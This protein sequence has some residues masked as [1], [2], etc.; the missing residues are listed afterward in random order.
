[1]CLLLLSIGYVFSLHVYGESSILQTLAWDLSTVD[2]NIGPM[3]TFT[4]MWVEKPITDTMSLLTKIGK[5]TAIMT[6]MRV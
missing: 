5:K 2:P 4:Q 1:V 3:T 6:T